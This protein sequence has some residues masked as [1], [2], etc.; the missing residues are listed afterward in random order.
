MLCEMAKWIWVK[1]SFVNH[2]IA[3]EF[4]S[5]EQ[6]IH[7]VINRNQINIL[8]QGEKREKTITNS[9][10]FVQYKLG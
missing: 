1:L 7:T 10:E 4:I 5:L 8:K 6:C 3:L 9:I 2:F